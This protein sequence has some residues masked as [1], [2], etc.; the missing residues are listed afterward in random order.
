MAVRGFV[1]ALM[2]A[3]LPAA[4]PATASAAGGGTP[5]GQTPAEP[6]ITPAPSP[7]DGNAMWIWQLPKAGTWA[8]VAR[9]AKA[10]NVSALY[11]K[12]AN[13][14]FEWSQFTPAM[15][16]YFQAQGLK[17]CGWAYLYGGS[18]KWGTPAQEAVASANAYLKDG[19]DCF[20][21]DP[22]SEYEGRDRYVAADTYMTKLRQLV[23]P[24][25]P[26]ALATFPYVDFHPS[27]PY[28]VF[29][30]PD[31]G[32]QANTPQMYWDTIRVTPD[33]IFSRTYGWNALYRRPIYPIGQTY[34]GEGRS[35]FPKTNDIKRFRVLSAAY[36]SPGVS[37]W[38]WSEGSAAGFRAATKP[39]T[40]T[41]AP[42]Q[43]VLPTIA[44]GS[45][46]DW[47]VWAQEH[48]N[49]AGRLVAVT[50]S[51]GAQTQKAVKSFQAASAL[52]V[53][54]KLDPVTWAALLQQTPVPTHW[55][56]TRKGP[57]SA[58]AAGLGGSAPQS[59]SLPAK[60][61]ELAGTPR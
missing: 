13:G 18:P 12:S 35:T 16:D 5:T 46:G 43:A 1:A 47:V 19:A 52:P 54:G 4:V 31:G 58:A 57:A 49:G 50:G 61:D 27:M 41:A 42:K 2:L 55:A 53:T 11:I 30:R 24:E 10:N 20:I 56:K 45:K 15:V 25:F 6:G 36:G 21:M 51:F 17:V 3:L 32:A 26:V 38:E 60:R 8:Q 33:R 28:S 44:R 23:G 48:L 39:L 59:A 29:M 34:M 14:S 37:W 7:F 9:K 40:S 22:E